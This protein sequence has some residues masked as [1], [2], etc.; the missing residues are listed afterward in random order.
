MD[1]IVLVLFGVGIPGDHLVPQLEQE[2]AV[3][4]VRWREQE[5]VSFIN[6][7]VV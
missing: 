3:D 7:P 5:I 4:V 6:L 2:L 1:K